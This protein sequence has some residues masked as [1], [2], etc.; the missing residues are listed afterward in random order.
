MPLYD[1]LRSTDAL[2]SCPPRKDLIGGL[3]QENSA[4][5][6]YG[7]TAS[8]KTL[9]ALHMAL[10]LSAGRA[11]RGKDIEAAP[12]LYVA[13]EDV[14]GSAARVRAWISRYGR[15]GEMGW[16]LRTV[17]ILAPGV[18]DELI[19]VCK[20][21]APRL[22]VIDTLA[23]CTPGLEENSPKE[24][25][26]L[27]QALERLLDG[28]GACVLLVHHTGKDTARGPRGSNAL[29]AAV[30]TSIE[31]QRT[32]TGMTA[33]VKKQKNGADGEVMR[34][35]LE[36][37]GDS[38]VLVDDGESAS[39]PTGWRPTVLMGRVSDFLAR[40]QVAVSQATVL[41]GVRGKSDAVRE[42]IRCLV[43]EGYATAANGSRGALQLQ[44]VRPYNEE[45]D[46]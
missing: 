39:A 43:D 30:D 8:A 27:V 28:T 38:V 31:T 40:Q 13:A 17:P 35:R 25:G 45:E 12:V 29:L 26:L 10:S 18:V 44:L 3:F 19:E 24:M 22:V 14:A 7:P 32:R 23:R 15:P 6:V 1:D 46:Q 5:M 42:A 9:L 37:E 41:G 33:I 4:V 21:F 20:L 36:P 11:W 2:L 34:F 16:L